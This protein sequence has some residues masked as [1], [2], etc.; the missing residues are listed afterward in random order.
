MIPDWL[1]QWRG[2]ATLFDLKEKIRKHVSAKSASLC[3]T[4]ETAEGKL[5]RDVRFVA[6]LEFFALFEVVFKFLQRSDVP[7]NFLLHFFGLFCLALLKRPN[8]ILI[9]LRLF[10]IF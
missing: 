2:K 7:S 6:V 4:L 1:R 5:K 10:F 8:K 9:N 3:V